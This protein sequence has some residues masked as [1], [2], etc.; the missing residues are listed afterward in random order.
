MWR[1]HVTIWTVVTILVVSGVTWG[2]ETR[3]M[4]SATRGRVRLT[5]RDGF[6]GIAPQFTCRSSATGR[7][8]CLSFHG[9]VDDSCYTLSFRPC[10]TFRWTLRFDSGVIC[11]GG[12]SYGGVGDGWLIGPYACV[13]DAGIVVDVGVLVD[14]KP[15]D[16][17][18][19]VVSCRNTT[20]EALGF[21]GGRLRCS[22]RCGLDVSRCTRPSGPV[23]GCCQAGGSSVPPSWVDLSIADGAPMPGACL[24]IALFLG[25]RCASTRCSSP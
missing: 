20:C 24:P 21:S 10:E 14:P 19:S 16:G 4:Y 13:N 18:N 1:P 3:V 23:T 6:V 15:R 5:A 12:Q 2:R 22:R 25:R 17:C 9:N 7:G 8:R 11:G